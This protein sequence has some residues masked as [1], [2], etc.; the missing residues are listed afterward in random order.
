MDS[1]YTTRPSPERAIAPVHMPHGWQ[2]VYMVVPAAAVAGSSRAAQRASLS[3]GWAVMS[4]SDV[5]V[6]WSSA[7]TSPA[8]LTSSDP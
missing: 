5:T 4:R 1:A 2:L 6:L 3:S 7:S 8:A